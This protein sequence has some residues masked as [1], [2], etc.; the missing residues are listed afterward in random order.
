MHEAHFSTYYFFN[1]PLSFEIFVFVA[2]DV[3]VLCFFISEKG[4]VIDEY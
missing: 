3:A 4:K 1:V 2:G